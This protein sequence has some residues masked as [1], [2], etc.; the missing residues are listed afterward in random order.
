MYIG[1]TG[2]SVRYLSFAVAVA[3]L[4]PVL[5]RAQ[6]EP[7]VVHTRDGGSTE[8]L[9][10]IYIPPLLNAPFT[11]IVHTEWSRPIPGGGSFTAVNQRRVARDSHGRIYEER[12]L[13]V[14]KDGKEKSEMNVI[15]IADPSAHTLYN[16]F[17]S[18]RQCQLLLYTES[19]TSIY[20]PATA[21]TGPLPNNQGFSTHEDLGV[22]DI[23]SVE[24]HG[25]RDTTTLNPGVFGNDRPLV[26]TREFWHSSSL[27]INLLSILD[28]WRTGKQTFTLTDVSISEPDFKLF[29][30]PEGFEVIDR[31]HPKTGNTGEP[32]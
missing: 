22:R 6:S 17:I 8:V 30:L 10:S 29:E 7:Q 28:S 13:L 32:Q 27:G 20:T 12:W 4:A 31:R 1:R 9:Q 3:F 2:G 16:C 21:R 24:T 15:Q 11:A 19:A 26:T 25:S 14:P 23:D 5:L 18:Q